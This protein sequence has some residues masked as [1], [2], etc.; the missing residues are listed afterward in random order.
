MV[1]LNRHMFMYAI[2]FIFYFLNNSYFNGYTSDDY[3]RLI[4]VDLAGPIT[5]L[6]LLIY[7][8]YYKVRIKVN[9]IVLRYLFIFFG[10][11]FFVSI[12]RN[13]LYSSLR[14][15][16][17]ILITYS[18]AFGLSLIFHQIPFIKSLQLFILIVVFFILPI[19]FFVQYTKLGGFALF[20]DR[21]GG[22]DT[23]RFGGA[24]Y[25]AHNGMILGFIAILL[26]Y[27]VFVKKI[28][29][30]INFILLIIVFFSIIL[31][32]CRSVWGGVAISIY[33]M[34]YLF[35]KSKS[36]RRLSIFLSIVITIVAV[37][38]LIAKSV[39][40]GNTVDDA[41]FRIIIWSRAIEGILES[42]I[43]GYG[44]F[45]Y[46]QS[47]FEAISDISQNLNDPHNS[48][49]DLFL[50]NGLPASLLFIILFYKIYQNFK[51]HSSFVELT[52]IFLFWLIVP[53]FWGHIYKGTT[54]FIQFFFPLSV[55]SVILHPD[56]YSMKF[57]KNK[58][59]VE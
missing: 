53:F 27:L 51:N 32:D 25:H 1:R 36:L 33:S 39:T 46:F 56:I 3:T 13:D 21:M 44:N 55:F 50:Q 54:G 43:L 47:N 30:N 22:E 4:P 7:I 18:V 45:N 20:P 57:L 40:V 24:L 48:F 34:F 17:S 41:S 8:V 52:P 23:L 49:L 58:Y 38:Y 10:S 15:F 26:F 37:N 12:L 31:T 59:Q 19:N 28:N 11:L 5:I 35:V 6:A 16:S 14:N 2:I 42:P 29:R 9:K